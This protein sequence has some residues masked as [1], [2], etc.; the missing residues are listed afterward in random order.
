M[1][2]TNVL[3]RIFNIKYNNGHATCFVLDRDKKQYL[4]TAKHIVKD[5]LKSDRIQ[6]YK[7]GTWQYLDVILLG[8]CQDD[9]DIT[10]LRPSIQLA[11]SSYCL[12]ASVANISWGQ[13][14]YFL[15]FPYGLRGEVGKFNNEFPFAFVKK[16]IVSMM[17]FD[18]DEVINKLYLDGHNN[19]GFSGAP[20]VISNIG[21]PPSEDNPYRLIAVISGMRYE[22]EPVY[23]ELQSKTHLTYRYNTGIILAYPINHA[24]AVIDSNPDGCEI[25]Y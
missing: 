15:G 5:I 10:I 1:I 4:I 3:R 16:A 20:V 2:T 18:D 6:I 22:Y 24:L 13:D 19:P 25:I 8:H 7:D 14:V 17:C 23:D 11:H 21:Q 12:E 9:I